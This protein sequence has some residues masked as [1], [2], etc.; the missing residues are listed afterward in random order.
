VIIDVGAARGDYA[1]RAAMLFPITRAVMAEARPNAAR[2]IRERFRCD[3]RFSVVEAA[4]SDQC[5]ETVFHVNEMKDS[6]SILNVNRTATE[7]AFGKSFGTVEEIIVK[8]LTLDALYENENLHA[9]DL[10]KV[11]IQGAERRFDCR[12]RRSFGKNPRRAPRGELRAVLRWSSVVSR[13]RGDHDCG[14]FSPALASRA[15]AQPEWRFSLLRRCPLSAP[16]RL[17]Q[18]RMF[19]LAPARDF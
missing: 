13:D 19:L 9:V 5:G 16:G 18:N 11:D 3:P 1:A 12:W 4:I 7:S 8:T 17:M 10:L 6:S 15:Q 2:D 14:R